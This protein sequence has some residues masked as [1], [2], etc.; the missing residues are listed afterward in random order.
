MNSH[1]SNNLFNI[2]TGQV[3]NKKLVLKVHKH[4]SPEIHKFV[5]VEFFIDREFL[6]NNIFHKEVITINLIDLSP[7][8]F[9]E[10][11]FSAHY[12]PVSPFVE[13]EKISLTNGHVFIPHQDCRGYK[14][15][16]WVMNEIVTWASQW[17]NADIE[18]I[19]LGYG[20]ATIENKV[21]RN[22]FYEGFGIKF[23]YFENDK[24]SGYSLPM[25]SSDLTNNKSWDKNFSGNIKVIDVIDF[26]K[27]T[28]KELRSANKKVAVIKDL[29][30]YPY[31]YKI[32][33]KSF[34]SIIK[35]FF[36]N[37]N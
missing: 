24:L 5:F 14:I 13:K 21:R 10:F 18:K 26:I 27:E 29:R 8:S 20:D 17:P 3:N 32:Q 12:L 19:V 4:N 30:N 7:P 2:I 9:H 16:T 31:N 35:S 34:F 15:G 1:S 23:N 25:K 28:T 6:G 36:R 37:E 22:K 33:K 11:S